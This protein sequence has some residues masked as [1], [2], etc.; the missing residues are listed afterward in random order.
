MSP[1]ATPISSSPAALILR[2]KPL[3]S[4]PADYQRDRDKPPPKPWFADLSEDECLRHLQALDDQP[5]PAPRR[6]NRKQTPSVTRYIKQARKAG[7]CGPVQIEITDTKG[8]SV[9]VTSNQ[10]DQAASVYVNPWDEVNK[11]ATH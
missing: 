8:R 2:R 9:K 3:V 4:R 1:P 7:D 5:V 6:G 10:Q 11:N